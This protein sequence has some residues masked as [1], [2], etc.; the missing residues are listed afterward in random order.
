MNKSKLIVCFM[1]NGKNAISSSF[2]DIAEE[3]VRYRNCKFFLLDENHINGEG[4]DYVAVDFHNEPLIYKVASLLRFYAKFIFYIKREHVKKIFFYFD[5]TFYNTITWL[6]LKCF[7]VKKIIW[8][9]DVKLHSGG[10]LREKII[11]LLNSKLWD[12]HRDKFIVS[13]KNAKYELVGKYNIDQENVY[14]CWLPEMTSMNFPEIKA[15]KKYDYIFFGRLE[16]YKGIDVLLD[17]VKYYKNKKFLIVGRGPMER[18]IKNCKK[19]T[20]NLEFINEYV[21]NYELAEYI[22]SSKCVLLP[23][24]SAT[25]SQTVQIANYYGVPVI[26]TKVGCFEE[27]ITND[28]GWLANDTSVK[29]FVEIMDELDNNVL[30]SRLIKEKSAIHHSIKYCAKKII[31]LM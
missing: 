18:E 22:A 26:A 16:E 9:H 20:C 30:D 29:A 25:G 14:I 6:L 24:R 23:Y 19:Y 8:I 3:I 12:K 10:T 2:S 4:K 27:Y 5:N 7:K 21:P 17:L 31:S 15:E 1:T 13:Y 28:N 11:R